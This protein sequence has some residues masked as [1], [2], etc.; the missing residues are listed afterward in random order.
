MNK[1]NMRCVTCHRDMPSAG[2]AALHKMYDH[3][4]QNAERA[5]RTEQALRFLRDAPS[6][7]IVLCRSL[8][9]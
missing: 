4:V 5:K 2:V 9:T 1:P 8:L 7:R 3:I 6:P